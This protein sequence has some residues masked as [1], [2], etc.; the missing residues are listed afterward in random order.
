MLLAINL[1]PFKKVW[2]IIA[3]R[4]VKIY[5]IGKHVHTFHKKKTLTN[6][7][8]S[9]IISFNGDDGDGVRYSAQESPRLVRAGAG[10]R[11]GPITSEPDG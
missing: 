8:S 2:R 11:A 1:P 5:H 7:L 3:C 9:A 10:E 6:P 4:N